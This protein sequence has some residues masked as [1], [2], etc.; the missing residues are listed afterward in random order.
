MRAKAVH[1]ILGFYSS[2]EGD[3]K[4]AY[5]AA[6]SEHPIS[7]KLFQNEADDRSQPYTQLRIDGESLIVVT[8]AVPELDRV[9][10]ALESTGSPAIFVLHEDLAQP[11]AQ[12]PGSGSVVT[13]LH[14]NEVTLEEARRDLAAAAGM[15]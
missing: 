14:E 5:Q 7:A 15:G 9:I 6:V 11:P 1:T 4:E 2:G 8:A 13:R 12:A 10:T 3:P